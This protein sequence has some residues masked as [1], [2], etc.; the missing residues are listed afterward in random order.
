MPSTRPLRN[1]FSSGNR[2]QTKTRTETNERPALAFDQLE[3]RCMLASAS[4]SNG[5]LTVIGDPGNDVIEVTRL[6]SA[7]VL[8][9]VEI[10]GGQ[11]QQFS[12]VTLTKVYGGDGND[13]ITIDGYLPTELYGQN[14]DDTIN[15]GTTIDK[16]YGANGSDTI[17]GHAGDD[18][19]YGQNDLDY[20]YGGDGNDLIN[21]GDGHDRLWGDDGNDTM[22]GLDGNDTLLAGNGDDSVFGHN[23]NDFVYGQ[24][25]VDLVYGND[26][27]DT[28][29]GGAGNDK[30]YGQNGNDIG[31]GHHG[32]D[33]VNGGAGD[34]VLHGDVGND[35]VYGLDGADTLYG[36]DGDDFITGGNHVDI[37]Y[38]GLG[39]DSIHGQGDRDFLYGQGG[40]DL[41]R[42][43][44]G[45]DV[46]NGGGGNDTLYGDDDDDRVYGYSGTDTLFGGSG[47]DGLFGGRG[48]TDI[49]DGGADADRMLVFGINPQFDAN[50]F[51]TTVDNEETINNLQSTD[52]V[53][54]F[55]DHPGMSLDVGGGNIITLAAG[56]WTDT[57]IVNTD[58][59]LQVL[60]L[61]TTNADLLQYAGSGALAFARLGAQTSG[62][63]TLFG[64]NTGGG[65]MYLTG[66]VF[67]S[68]DQLRSTTI[69]E[70]AHN[71]DQTIENPFIPSFQAIS[72]WQFSGGQWTFGANPGFAH[73]SALANPYEDFAY[74]FDSYFMD[75][76]FNNPLNR[77]LIAAKLANVQAFLD[78]L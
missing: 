28:V 57:E 68:I 35:N 32:D 54:Y 58:S 77:N 65:S 67:S 47:K 25:G 18:L 69:H 15:G 39:D 29:H 75:Q 10:N 40:H 61:H 38:G 13:Q 50:G 5:I 9:E 46:V 41:V 14:G 74:T 20:I 19:L 45:N 42:G 37:I 16:I 7:G 8:V 60:H 55:Y 27:D 63:G 64:F 26:G 48:G 17:Y 72:N 44:V 43:G 70:I 36:D 30:V 76:Y 4:M 22:Y 6:I 34:D 62:T 33:I 59:A 1:L 73:P 71:F 12:N 66:N 23:G 53:V 56:A 24:G 21:G 49:F 52:A 3:A 51:L 2:K 78:T 11:P 31:F